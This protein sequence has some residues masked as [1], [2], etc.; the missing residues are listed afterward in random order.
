MRE[1]QAICKEIGLPDAID[2]EE[3]IAKDAVKEAIALHHLTLLKRE[4]KVEAVAQTD[5]RIVCL[6]ERE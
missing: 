3:N 1:V 2:N 5:M 4:M 6:F